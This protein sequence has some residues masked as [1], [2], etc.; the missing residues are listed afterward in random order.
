MVETHDQLES[1]TGNIAAGRIAD[2]NGVFGTVP[3]AWFY[4]DI[5]IDCHGSAQNGVSI[6]RPALEGTRCSQ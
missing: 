1:G 4:D 3:G 2:L 6:S 5:A